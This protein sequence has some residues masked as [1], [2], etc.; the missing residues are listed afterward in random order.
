MT[1]ASIGRK[2]ANCK[3]FAW[4]LAPLLICRASLNSQ[5]DV[6]LMQQLR[7]K[8][9]FTWS[10]LTPCSGQESVGLKTLFCIFWNSSGVLHDRVSEMSLMATPYV[11]YYKLIKVANK[12]CSH[13]DNTS[14]NC[15]P[16][17][18]DDN[19]RKHTANQR[20]N[21]FSTLNCYACRHS[22][23]S[24]FSD[25]R[26]HYFSTLFKKSFSNTVLD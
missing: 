19:A 25:I 1:C 14:E 20:K 3:T 21:Y 12:Y 22:S 8:G 7:E 11:K 23:Y 24:S 6:D 2:A 15:G 17:R 10:P 4:S 16:L 13:Y 9:W 18:L 26:N 5:I